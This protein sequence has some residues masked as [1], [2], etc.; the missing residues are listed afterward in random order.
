MCQPPYKSAPL[1]QTFALLLGVFSSILYFSITRLWTFNLDII[2]VV[3]WR[4]TIEDK[5]IAAAYKSTYNHT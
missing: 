1:N 2:F 5:M 3:Y 4:L